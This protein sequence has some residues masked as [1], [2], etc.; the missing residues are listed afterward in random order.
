MKKEDDS[1]NEKYVYS[2]VPHS[3]VKW[4]FCAE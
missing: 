3:C 1:I 2:V 4:K